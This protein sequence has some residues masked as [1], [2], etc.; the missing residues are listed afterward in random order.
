MHNP[1]SLKTRK[2]TVQSHPFAPCLY[3]QRGVVGIGNKI[4][5]SI[6]VTAQTGKDSPVLFTGSQDL[7]AFQSAERLHEF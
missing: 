4:S 6:A 3:G 7:H 5:T 2:S 1:K